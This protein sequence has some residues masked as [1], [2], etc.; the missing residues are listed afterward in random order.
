MI[1]KQANDR[2]IELN[3]R[4]RNKAESD[5]FFLLL[6]RLGRYPLTGRNDPP[7]G[8]DLDPD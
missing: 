2:V 6:K 3:S 4:D 5:E 7:Q 1:Y 8:A